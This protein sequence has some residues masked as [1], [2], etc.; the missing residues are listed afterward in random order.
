MN[1]GRHA[2]EI[3]LLRIGD[4]FGPDR[5]AILRI[6]RQEI[7]IAGTANDFAVRERRTAVRRRR[8]VFMQRVRTRPNHAAVSAIE[9]NRIVCSRQVHSARRYDRSGLRWLFVGE[10]VCAGL[11]QL[12]Y[13][14]RRDLLE[15]RVARS[16]HVVIDIDPVAGARVAVRLGRRLH[17]QRPKSE[18]L[19]DDQGRQ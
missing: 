10:A 3:A 17:S 13:V 14:A 2:D 6:E 18:Q 19:H 15:M 4:L 12:R 16:R 9:S 1:Q 11:D 7:T 5:V 8:L